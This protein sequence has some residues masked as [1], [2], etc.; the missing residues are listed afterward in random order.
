[1]DLKGSTDLEWH[2]CNTVGLMMTIKKK[3]ESAAESGILDLLYSTL[4]SSMSK[5]GTYITHSVTLRFRCVVL[6]AANLEIDIE[7]NTGGLYVVE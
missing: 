7:R 3:K 5:A 4:Y 2:F 6:A 1:M